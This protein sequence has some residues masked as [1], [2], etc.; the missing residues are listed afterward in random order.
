[1]ANLKTFVNISDDRIKS[2]IGVPVDRTKDILGSL[3]N[4]F[5]ALAP[6]G[7]VL[8]VLSDT[9]IK[10][11][12]TINSTNADGHKIEQSTNG[13]DYSIIATVTGSTATYTKTGLTAGILYYYR[14]RAYKNTSYSNYCTAESVS[15]DINPSSI[16]NLKVWFDSETTINSS[17]LVSQLTDKSGLNN[18]AVQST[19]GLKPTLV[20][21]SL[22]GRST[23]RFD[24]DNDIMTFPS[25]GIS[26]PYVF[27]IVVK[28]LENASNA[29][30][31]GTNA[32]PI[33]CPLYITSGKYQ[34]WAG[35]NNSAPETAHI[36][37]SAFV[38][39]FNNTSSKYY[40]NGTT[41]NPSTFG[42]A[43]I[44]KP[45]D[46]GRYGGSDAYSLNFDF[47][48][49]LIY[50]GTHDDTTRD[51]ILRYL[52]NKYNSPFI[53]HFDGIFDS[54]VEYTDKT[55][56]K[57]RSAFSEYKFNYSNTSLRIK[58][59][60][61]IGAS[62]PD[63][64]HLSIYVNGVFNQKVQFLS[65]DTI[66]KDITLP[67]GNK[68]VSIVEPSLSRINDV[69]DALGVF[70]TSILAL[71]SYKKITIGNV[72][73][74]IVF[75]GDSITV[76]GN[77]ETPANEAYSA[78]FRVENN[79]NITVL[80]WGY[81]GI[82]SF[83]NGAPKINATIGW[84]TNAFNNV[85]TDKILVILLG[86]NDHAITGMSTSDFTTYYGALLDAI[87]SDD[88]GIY[89]Y[90]VSPTLRDDI[91]EDSTLDEYRSA[92]STLCSARSTYCTYINGKT[93]LSVSDL[94]DTVHP[95]TSGHKKL[96]DAIYSA[97]YN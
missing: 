55:T 56:Y 19:D 81:A 45:I 15:T 23:I 42:T 9:S 89:I 18:H 85:T 27:Y 62:Y 82:N 33:V 25:I 79:K 17:N 39:E 58:A 47:Y 97:I 26:Q 31:M 87:H 21:N 48:E 64:S 54:S 76:G 75:L 35:A 2:A 73:E 59:T 10:I 61:T 57:I 88:E 50:T 94:D 36:E 77:S 90:C 44:S 71:P 34:A 84:L 70:V 4:V 66:Y 30:T 49:L 52:G 5:D 13:T 93:I 51:S 46:I 92:I 22:N 86:T 3:L 40:R 24:G 1:M 43:G 16:S 28:L 37:L 41:I 53:I 96:K 91:Y 38:T 12:F 60:S 68:L 29:G 80:G 83:G 6:S 7:L 63:Y 72:S 65:T 67:A 95:S 69:G 8:T 32:A 20:S 74:K 14:I 78:L 11:D